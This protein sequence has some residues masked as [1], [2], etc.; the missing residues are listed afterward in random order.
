[1]NTLNVEKKFIK[2]L[3]KKG[4]KEIRDILLEQFDNK[5]F[6]ARIIDRVTSFEDACEETGQDPN[7]KKFTTGTPDDIAYQKKKVIVKAL[8]EEW[9]PDW[10]D[11][12]QKKWYP[13]FRWSA[14]SG[15]DFSYSYYYYGNPFTIVGSR[16]C[17]PT[18]ELSDYFGKHFIDIHRDFLNP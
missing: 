4:S 6:L 13:W 2:K 11:G 12:S 5:M 10:N 8:C 9:V 15:F 17:F 18:Q 3:Y 16:L 1:M 14:G 7:D